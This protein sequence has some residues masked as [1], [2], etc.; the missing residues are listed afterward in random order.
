[1]AMKWYVVQAFSGYE[2]HVQR[3]LQEHIDR[4]GAEM[5]KYFG[6]ILVPTERSGRDESRAETDQ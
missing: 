6:E 5:Q 1:M 2:K 3:S 4:K